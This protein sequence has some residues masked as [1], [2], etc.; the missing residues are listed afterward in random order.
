MAILNFTKN[1]LKLAENRKIKDS[2]RTGPPRKVVDGSL[3]PS[4]D[5]EAGSTI[6]I[7]GV[8][9]GFFNYEVSVILNV[10]IFNLNIYLLPNVSNGHLGKCLLFAGPKS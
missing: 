8:W 7:F 9:N 5:P 10:K 6:K 1:T 4:H 3:G 2:R